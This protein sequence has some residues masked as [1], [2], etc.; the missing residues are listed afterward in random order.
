MIAGFGQHEPRVQLPAGRR[1]LQI[2]G[3]D[4]AISSHAEFSGEIDATEFKAHRRLIGQFRES[5]AIIDGLRQLPGCADAIA[6]LIDQK[7]QGAFVVVRDR[8]LQPFAG[9]LSLRGC[10]IEVIPHTQPAHRVHISR[11][12]LH[13]LGPDA[14]G[15]SGVARVFLRFFAFLRELRRLLSQPLFRYG[16]AVIGSGLH[17]GASG[18]FGPLAAVRAVHQFKPVLTHRVHRA[19]ERFLA[20]RREPVVVGI[21]G[22]DPLVLP[23]DARVLLGEHFLLLIVVAVLRLRRAKL[24]RLVGL[25]NR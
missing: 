25:G 19:R 24:C 17:P 12:R 20:Q 13:N 5:P 14:L 4:C 21:Q 22:T 16:I 11:F 2:G 6:G 18:L 10:S 23:G 9:K 1:F 7:E 3:G 15:E 8:L